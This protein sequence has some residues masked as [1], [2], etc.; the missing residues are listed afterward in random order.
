M[1]L[2]ELAVGDRHGEI[3]DGVQRTGFRVVVFGRPAD[4][5]L[6]VNRFLHST[7]PNCPSPRTAYPDASRDR[8]GATGA[9]RNFMSENGLPR[10]TKGR[11]IFPFR[12]YTQGPDRADSRV[13]Y[14]PYRW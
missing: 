6:A 10:P 7:F 1:R 3:V 9:P 4:N 11:R 5:E 13:L 2:G 8:T 12:P 14:Q